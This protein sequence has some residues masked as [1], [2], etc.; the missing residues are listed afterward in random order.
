MSEYLKALE[1]QRRAFEAQ[2]GSIEELGYEDKTK[3]TGDEVEEMSDD[4]EMESQDEG[5]EDQEEYD[6][7]EEFHGFDD[8]DTEQTS[9]SREAPKPVVVKFKDSS[10]TY[11]PSKQEL[12]LIR[13]GKI[14]TMEQQRL[15]DERILKLQLA[16]SK[17]T[18]DEENLK[19]DLEL[20][21][22]LKESHFLNN[23]HNDFSGALL[24]LQT[25]DYEEPIGKAR[26]RAL[27]SR[28]LQVSE[29]NKNQH[30]KLEKMPMSMRKG[31]I[32]ATKQ[33]ISKYERDARENGVILSKVK[34]GQLRDLSNGKGS[35]SIFTRIG[36][37]TKKRSI[38]RDRGLQINSVGRST[39]NGLILNEKDLAKIN[40]PSHGRRSRK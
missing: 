22:L 40:G 3:V 12:K 26:R 32:S 4:S 18:N 21:R 7:E 19:N 33:R 30:S 10:S 20:Q 24:T 31:M 15:E 9:S 38:I 35:T 6:D 16:R 17:D 2:F 14:L 8:D 34:K 37:G 28:I 23:T 11:T 25:I 36:N 13:K 27:D 29:L 1:L 39:R 5:S